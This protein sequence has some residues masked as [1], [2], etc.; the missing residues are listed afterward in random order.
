[1][2]NITIRKLHTGET[3]PLDLL[4]LA[5]SCTKAIGDYTKRGDC[6]LA[7][8]NDITVG[9][10]VLIHTRPFTVEL[11]NVSV[12]ESYQGKGIGKM[13]IPFN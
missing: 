11:V 8:I 10:Y 9:C 5:Y 13:R 2:N 6:F 7:I 12:M 4:L 1:M 3:I